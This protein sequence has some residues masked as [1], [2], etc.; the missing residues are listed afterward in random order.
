M[1]NHFYCVLRGLL[2]LGLCQSSML[3]AAELTTVEE[4][5]LIE[6]QDTQID[7]KRHSIGQWI[8]QSAHKIDDWFG[9]PDPDQPASASLRIILDNDWNRYDQYEIRPRIRGKIRLPTLEKKFSVVFGDDSL[10]NELDQNI[11]IRNENPKLDN[12][13]RYNSSRTRDDNS[14]IALRWSQLSERFGVDTDVDVGIRSGDDVYVRFEVAKDWQLN[15]KLSSR[16]EQ[17][18]R[19][20]L[21]SEN[22]FRTNLELSYLEHPSTFLSNQF[23]LIFAD[24]QQEDLRW[25]NYSFRQHQMFT[26]NRFNYG[27]YT[28][29]HYQQDDL[30]L[31]QWGPFVSWRQPFWREWFF[32]QTDLNYFNDDRLDRDHYLSA[33]LRLEAL[34]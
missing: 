6:N 16:A 33:L 7:Q 22:Y 13:Q 18:Y 19:Y 17:I 24:A 23:S 2:F 14:S 29:G 31:N 3:S 34:F 11:A 1:P 28:G 9:E 4:P 21:D 15:E 10:D 5:I 27:L 30:R 8:D 26:G 20:G 12:D 32:V 25:H